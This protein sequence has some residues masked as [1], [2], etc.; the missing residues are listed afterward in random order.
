MT[1]LKDSAFGDQ[2]APFVYPSGPG[3][4]GVS[5]SVKAA[6]SVV[7]HVGP[8]QRK[9]LDYLFEQRLSGGIFTEII[10]GTGLTAGTVCGRMVE[11]VEA[12]LVQ[13]NGTRPTPSRRQA[14]VYVH[15]DFARADGRRPTA[16]KEL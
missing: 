3:H 8:A 5:T 13:I 9:I 12:G 2:P 4:R 14:R 10:D 15:R 6:A 1:G 7:A 11:L 16:G